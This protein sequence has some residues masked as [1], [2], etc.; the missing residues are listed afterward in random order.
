[1]KRTSN[2]FHILLL[3][4]SVFGADADK[5]KA[6]S[7]FEG[8]SVT[9]N[10]DKDI[11]GIFLVIWRF[12]DKGTLIAQFIDKEISYPNHTGIF[13]ER[14]KLNETGS[15]TIQHTKDTDAG[16][17][18]VKINGNKN[19]LYKKFIVTVSGSGLSPGAVAGIVVL[20][21][22]LFAVAAVL[23]FLYYRHK[24]S[25][26]H[27]QLDN[28][29]ETAVGEDVTI[30]PETKLHPGDEIQWWFWNELS[31]IAG[32]KDGEIFTS[33][34]PKWKV[35]DGLKL[36]KK[37]GSLTINNIGRKLTG[38]YTLEIIRGSGE[39]IRRTFPVL[40]KE[41]KIAAQK[42]ASE[43]LKPD[44][45][46]QRDDEIQW[47]FGNKNDLI[48][49]M[50]GVTREIIY[51]DERFKD[52]LE[53]DK[54][55]GS[56]TINNI[57]FKHT[58]VFKMKIS[59]WRRNKIQIFSLYIPLEETIFTEGDTAVLQ[60]GAEIQIEDEVEWRFKGFK[61]PI[62][63][64]KD[65]Q[66]DFPSARPG[67]RFKETLDLDEKT[68]SLI[69]KNGRRKHSGRY[70]LQIKNSTGAPVRAFDVVFRSPAE[71]QELDLL[72]EEHQLLS[73]DF[74]DFEDIVY[75]NERMSPV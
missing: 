11:Q 54:K 71:N 39:N 72:P 58:G 61:S 15:L 69:I 46:I 1:M 30:K 24:S 45:E 47:L 23:G 70:C 50:T 16:L 6:V 42:G 34:N 35:K 40:I 74:E 7:V 56:L 38:N 60:S 17:Y 68:G 19:T 52:R 48:A 28:I 22:V 43:T 44:T 8:E 14:L 4:C 12:G 62:A 51:P 36:D 20:L 65:G 37:T 5:V 73:G 53:L 67:E 27:K 25:E 41:N 3:I 18:T 59:S 32:I 63:K 26:L 13:R 55:T 10:P 66:K 21:L 31:P 49:K 64:I 9:L 2:F 75:A 33:N 29:Y 57:T